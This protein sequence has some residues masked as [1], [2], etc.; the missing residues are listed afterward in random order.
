MARAFWKGAMSFG[1]VVIPVKMYVATEAHT[2]SFHMLHKKCLTRPKQVLHCEKDKEYF[3]SKDTVRGY[4]YAKDQ[5]VVLD[6]EDFKSTSE[7]RSHHRHP[8]ICGV[9]AG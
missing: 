4:E 2:L 8:G 5:F 6:E 9:R 7:N 3:S 1:M